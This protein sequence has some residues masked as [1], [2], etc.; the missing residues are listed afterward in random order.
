[1][2]LF[3]WLVPRYLA[4]PVR[5]SLHSWS[6]RWSPDSAQG[7]LL[8]SLRGRIYLRLLDVD[9]DP[10]TR[11]PT[12]IA[13]LVFEAPWPAGREAVPTVFLRERALRG[14]DSTAIDVLSSRLVHA[15]RT[16]LGSRS[17]PWKEL[18]LDCDWSA[19]T[20]DAYFALL[21]A[22]GRRLDS[23]RTVSSTLRLHQVRDRQRMGV[24]PVKRVLLMLYNMGPASADP[25]DTVQLDLSSTT[26]WLPALESYPL[27]M[28]LALPV[29]TWWLH[30]RDTTVVGL[31]EGQLPDPALETALEPVGPGRYRLRRS[32]WVAGTFFREGDVVKV[33][34]ATPEALERLVALVAPHLKPDPGRDVSFFSLDALPSSRF[35]PSFLL[36]LARLLRAARPPS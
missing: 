29:W 13:P 10:R 23:G 11:A 2:A 18:Q 16:T 35:P 25:T 31:V 12:A 3:A 9:L 20:R 33:E 21:R 15:A 4:A 7:R 27:R 30:L 17:V 28:D 8:D 5:A 32:T 26:P 14:L 1:V 6:T 34:S 36:R 24:P 19:G 22:T